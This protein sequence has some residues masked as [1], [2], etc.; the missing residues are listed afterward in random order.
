MVIYPDLEDF[1]RVLGGTLAWDR[2]LTALANAPSTD[3]D[4]THS[5]GEPLTYRVTSAPQATRLTGHRRNLAVR[6]VLT[7]EATFAVAPV[8][9]LTPTDDYDDLSDRQH[10]EGAATEHVLT[11]GG[12]LVAGIDEA[13]RDVAVDGQVVLLR[14][15]V[16]GA[17]AVRW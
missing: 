15:T 5:G 6:H 7:G 11:R 17:A 9:T 12:V 16:E 10:F 3:Q 4:V 1:R 14:V 8:A 13:L 2:A